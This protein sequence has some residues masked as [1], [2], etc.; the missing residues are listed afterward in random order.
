MLR[1]FPNHC[2]IFLREFSIN[3]APKMAEMNDLVQLKYTFTPRKCLKTI[4]QTGPIQ[5]S[6]NTC[7][8]YIANSHSNLDLLSKCKR[9]FYSRNCEIIDY[10]YTTVCRQ[11]TDMCS[12]EG[13]Y[14]MKKP[15]K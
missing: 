3:I 4:S 2:K 7:V 8:H 9:F 12:I 6:C 14:Y 5:P 13:K 1:K 15:P 10:E 11:N